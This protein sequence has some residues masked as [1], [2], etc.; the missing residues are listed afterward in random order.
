MLVINPPKKLYDSQKKNMHIGALLRQNPSNLGS[1]A[2]AQFTSEWSLDKTETPGDTWWAGEP[3]AISLAL[4]VNI[5]EY[6]CGWEKDCSW[7]G[8]S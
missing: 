1:S 3:Y 7:S 2:L 6:W 4:L 5:I 8:F